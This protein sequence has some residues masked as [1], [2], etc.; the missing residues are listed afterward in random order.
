MAYGKKLWED[1]SL[2]ASGGLSCSTCHAGYN[3]LSKSFALP[4]PHKI[5][6]VQA[7]IGVETLVD[8]EQIVQFCMMSPMQAKPLAWESKE[9]AA[10]S[11]FVVDFQKGYTPK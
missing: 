2:S 11:A 7:Q 8:V 4:Y 10:L 6:M 1:N 9:L 3:T 5:A